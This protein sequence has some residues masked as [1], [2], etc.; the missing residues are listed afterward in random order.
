MSTA[1]VRT[2]KPYKGIAME[3]MIASW[4]AKNTGRSL[5]EFREQAKRIA[6]TL[7]PGDMVLEVAPGPGYLAIA[8]A[9]LGNYRITG[10]DVSHSFVRIAQ[11]NAADAGVHV[12][13]R[14]GDAAALPFAAN[15]FDYLACRAAFKNF[16]NPVGALNEMHRVLRPGG[17]AVIVDMRKDASDQAIADQVAQM[18]LGLIGR[19][20]TSATLH[21]LKSRAYTRA[22]FERMI[23]ETPFGTAKIDDEPMGFEITLTK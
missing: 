15:W 5:T 16:G 2:A 19:F 11:K 3:G 13:F 6:A 1:G 4:Y 22:D 12:E 14:Q 20:M 23:A 8:L 17:R 21:S 10:L 7:K 9:Q 18:G